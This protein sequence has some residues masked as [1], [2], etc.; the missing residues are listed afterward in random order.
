MKVTLLMVQSLDGCITRHDEEHIYTW[1]SPEDQTFFKKMIDAAKIIVMGSSTY[2]A[3]KEI[4][5]KNPHKHRIVLTRDVKKYTQDHRS[6]QLEFSQES[7]TALLTRLS[8]EGHTEVLL[9]GGGIINTAFFQESLVDE[10]YITIEPRLFGKGKR[11]ITESLDVQLHLLSIQQLN[12]SGT[13]LLH[14][15]LK[16]E[17]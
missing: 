1:T 8:E 12:S 15:S 4:I 9:V 7:V 11:V 10:L 13:L 6:G 14:Y 17:K 5:Q 16:Q 2:T 3:A